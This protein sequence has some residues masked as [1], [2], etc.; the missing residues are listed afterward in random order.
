MMKIQEAILIAGREWENVRLSLRMC[1]DIGEFDSQSFVN[2]GSDWL[3]FIKS[4]VG[5]EYKLPRCGYC[6]HQ[7]SYV[8]ATLASKAGEKLGIKGELARTFGSG[9]SWVRTGCF[10]LNDVQ[11][12]QAAKR[13][14]FLKLFSPLGGDLTEWSF[15][16]PTVGTKIKLIFDTFAGWQNDPESYSHDIREY[17]DQIE[18]IWLGL[19]STLGFSGEFLE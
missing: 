11:K 13:M 19:S 15:K 10:S 5:M 7:A 16:S 9:Y 12:R 14:F 4:I 3:Y 1:G 6:S 8:F 17:R 2:N 18:P